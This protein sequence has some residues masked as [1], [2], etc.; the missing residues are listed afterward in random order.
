MTTSGNIIFLIVML[1]PS[2]ALIVWGF[3]KLADNSAKQRNEKESLHEKHNAFISGLITHIEGLPIPQGVTINILYGRDGITFVKDHQEITLD[4]ARVMSIDTFIGK[5][6][7]TQATG[8]I[9]GKLIVGGLGGAVLG[10]LIASKI[11]FVIS[12][13]KDDEYKSIIFEATGH[14]LSGNALNTTKIIKDFRANHNR[15][16]ESYEL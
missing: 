15:E 12:Y 4:I 7:Q 11:Y 9:A 14:E 5:D 1:V 16:T 3:Y 10:S 6:I 13:T 8:A 2:I